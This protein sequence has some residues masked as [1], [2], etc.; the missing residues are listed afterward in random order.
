MVLGIK[1]YVYTMFYKQITIYVRWILVATTDYCN[2][3]DNKEFTNFK[4]SR[5]HLCY[6]HCFPFKQNDDV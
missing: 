4:N 6:I 5:P 2:P 3:I 1:V